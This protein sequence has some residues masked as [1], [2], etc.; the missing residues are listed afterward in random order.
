MTG[1]MCKADITEEV[2]PLHFAIARAIKGTVEPFDVY[3][4]PYVATPTGARLFICNADSE[5][6]DGDICVWNEA[7]RTASAPFPECY[8]EF[9]DALAIAAAEEVWSLT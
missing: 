1:E 5:G 9:G 3:Q 6:E 2:F 4:G 8:D 7:T